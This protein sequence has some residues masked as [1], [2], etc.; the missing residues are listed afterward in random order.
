MLRCNRYREAFRPHPRIISSRRGT[1]ENHMRVFSR[2]AIA[3]PRSSKKFHDHKG[4]AHLS[5]SL[6]HN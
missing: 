5:V 3:N 1:P 4:S 2:S 6:K